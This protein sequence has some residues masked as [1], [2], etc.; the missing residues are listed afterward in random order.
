MATQ[1]LTPDQ[2]EADIARQREDLAATVTELQS[3][4]QAKAKATAYDPTELM[5]STV[6]WTSSEYVIV[7][8][9]AMN[10]QEGDR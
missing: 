8:S 10:S 7:I 2:L 3:Q 5:S 9:R 6:C 1:K 4:V